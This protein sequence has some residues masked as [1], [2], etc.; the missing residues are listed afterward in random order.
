M[1]KYRLVRI[2]AVI[3]Q[4]NDVFSQAAYRSGFETTSKQSA[5]VAHKELRPN[6]FWLHMMRILMKPISTPND[7][8][9]RHWSQSNYIFAPRF[10]LFY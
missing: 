9:N 6:P 4:F 2:N 8:Y 1:T 7:Y 3:L 10:A 5:G